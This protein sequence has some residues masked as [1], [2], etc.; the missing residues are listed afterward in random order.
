MKILLQQN[1]RA[2]LIR[3]PEPCWPPAVTKSLFPRG[4]EPTSPP[5]PLDHVVLDAFGY[6]TDR[7]NPPSVR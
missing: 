6:E 7:K 1:H 3:S 4:L 5:T 2:Y